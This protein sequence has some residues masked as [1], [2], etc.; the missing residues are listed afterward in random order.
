MDG[1]SWR[2]NGLISLF[3]PF[4]HVVCPDLLGHGESEKQPVPELYTQKNQAL[5]I[6]KIMDEL[7]YEKA[8]VIGYSSGA[9]V[10]LG[11]LNHHPERLHS[12]VLGEWDLKNGLPETPE[13][14]LNFDMFMFY[15]ASTAPELTSGVSLDNKESVKC[16]FNELRKYSGKKEASFPYKSPILLWS[17]A[18]DPYNLPMAEIAQKYGLSM[19]LG[20]GDH[21]SEFN[22]PDEASINEIFKFIETQEG[23]MSS[24]T[25]HENI[26]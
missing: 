7:G 15:A 3:S 19:T 8:H 13:G 5:S 2:N 11:L 16:F 6:V 24:F 21:L 9:W 18:S 17:G 25:F 14:K 22:K 23:S 1:K 10:A 20:K 12:V 26:N 4:F